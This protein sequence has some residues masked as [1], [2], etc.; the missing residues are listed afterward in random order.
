MGVAFAFKNNV[1][2]LKF[3]D[4]MTNDEST[5]VLSKLEEKIK[6]GRKQ[7]LFHL[8]KFQNHDEVSKS[9]VIHLIKFCF[10]QK[11]NI[12]LCLPQKSWSNYSSG[13]LSL[14]K[15]FNTEAEALLYLD[16]LS[17]D[18]ESKPLSFEELKAK[19]T[20]E[21]VKKYEIFHKPDD[22]DPYHLKKM[23]NV[24]FYTPTIEAIENLEKA[25]LDITKRKENIQR[26][27]LQCEQMSQQML[28]MSFARSKPVKESEFNFKTKNIQ[29]KEKSLLSIKKDLEE[30]ISSLKE[31]LNEATEAIQKT[32]QKT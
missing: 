32:T 31:N 2:V 1:Q 9:K 3:S 26:L 20:E 8:E 14:A 21:L 5:Q 4:I 15:M 17:R 30:K 23:Q 12:A 11:L 13:S 22:F 19:E 10:Q 25:S 18:P 29:D 7:F 28:E 6:Q 24:Y 16:N 27:E